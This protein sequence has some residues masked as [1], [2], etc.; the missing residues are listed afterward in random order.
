MEWID[1]TQDKDSW[2]DTVNALMGF[3]ALLAEELLA[4]QECLYSMEFVMKH[5]FLQI[6]CVHIFH[7][8]Q[9]N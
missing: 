2:R 8:M 6:G 3:W 7:Q 5:A 4:S 9:F 1:L